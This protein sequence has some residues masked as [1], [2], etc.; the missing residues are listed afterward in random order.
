MAADTGAALSAIS[1]ANA[2]AAGSSSSGG[3]TDRTRPAASAAGASTRRPVSIHSLAVPIPTTRGRNQ[4]LHPSGMI[5]RRVN[6]NP[7]RASVDARRTSIGSVMVAPMPTDAPFTAAMIGFFDAWMRN[8]SIPPPSRGTAPPG[9]GAAGSNA[10]APPE[11]SAPAQNA[12][13][14]PVTTTARTAS[15]AST[16]S[17]TLTNSRIV[18]ARNALRRSGRENVIVP[19]WSTTS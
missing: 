7:K 14:S 15:S 9:F 2:Y 1:R 12:R 4:L 8:A 11:M 13:P 10:S 19:M 6:T 16:R 3:W 5:P 17:S 18:A